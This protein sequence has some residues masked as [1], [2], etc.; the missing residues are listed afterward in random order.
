MSSRPTTSP[1]RPTSRPRTV[2]VVEERW[3]YRGHFDDHVAFDK[4]RE[5]RDYF[6]KRGFVR[7]RLGLCADRAQE[8]GQ[9]L[10][11][12]RRRR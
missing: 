6:D 11:E 1:F 12:R 8:P 4:D 7:A 9:R 5:A 2:D 10:R 3:I